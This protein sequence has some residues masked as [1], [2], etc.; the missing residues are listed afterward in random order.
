MNVLHPRILAAAP[1]PLPRST[2]SPGKPVGCLLAWTVTELANRSPRGREAEAVVR[3]EVKRMHRFRPENL[4]QSQHWVKG[5]HFTETPKRRALW[6]VRHLGRW[7]VEQ[8]SRNPDVNLRVF[9]NETLGLWANHSTF[10]QNWNGCLLGLVIGEVP[11]ISRCH[12]Y[13]SPF[14][15]HL[16]CDL[17]PMEKITG[18]HKNLGKKPTSDPFH[19]LG[20]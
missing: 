13:V 7:D 16:L 18:L 3:G 9:N 8:W 20:H 1:S 5:S 15:E 4:T 11:G 19:R 10:F 17:D 12:T 6:G 2:Q 14:A